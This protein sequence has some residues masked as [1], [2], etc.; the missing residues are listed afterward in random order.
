MTPAEK[1]SG[2]VISGS[3]ADGSPYTAEGTMQPD[4]SVLFRVP[5]LASIKGCRI[6][7]APDAPTP[8]EYVIEKAAA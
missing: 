5:H 6:T 3:M 2:Y 8:S 4:G 1:P 7:A